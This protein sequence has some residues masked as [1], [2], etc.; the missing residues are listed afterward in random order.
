MEGPPPP[1]DTTKLAAVVPPS[2][3]AAPPPLVDADP[4]PEKELSTREMFGLLT[5]QLSV[6]AQ[7]GRVNAQAT[8]T[9]TLVVLP[10]LD[11][12][13]LHIFGSKPPPLSPFSSTP[14]GELA[15]KPAKPPPLEKRQTL[16]EGTVETLTQEVANLRT[17]LGGV[18][19]LN[20]QQSKVMG[21]AAPSSN[22]TRRTAAYVGSRAFLK[23]LGLLVAAISAA[24]TLWRGVA[25]APAPLAPLPALSAPAGSR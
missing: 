10:R 9:L 1:R 23:D 2:K 17:E 4:F 16:T 25:P 12:L 18:R 21:I 8:E 14:P 11:R 15:I 20:V 3:E 13:D 6:I 7:Q 19:A 22:L 24:I 5:G